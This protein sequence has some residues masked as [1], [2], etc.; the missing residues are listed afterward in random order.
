MADPPPHLYRREALAAGR[1]EATVRRIFEVQRAV[2]AHGAQPVYTLAHLAQLTGVSWRYLRD[3]VARR[4][5]PYL[6]ISRP[7]RDGT[8]RPIASPEPV[9]MDVQRWL[10][11][12]V[13]CACDVDPAAY[14]YR[15]GRSIVDC[16]R[17]H[18]GARWLVKLDLHDFFGT[19]GERRVFRVF[20]ALG[21]PSLLS[22]EMTRL[23]TRVVIGGQ[24]RR[25]FY[26]Y[27]H[28]APYSV[29]IEGALPQ[30][31]PTSGALANAAMHSAD[32][33]LAELASSE[34]LVY[35]RYSDDI[36]LSAGTD[37]TR[38]RG[39]HVVNRAAAILGGAGFVLHRAKSRVVP[40][41]A[42]HVVL[43]LIVGEDEVRL[44]PEYKRRL[45]LH[46]RG[47][48]R[49][50]LAEHARSRHFDSI[51]SMINHVDG[52]IAFAASV[53]PV[54]AR[55]L[56][57]AWDDALRAGGYPMEPRR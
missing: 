10:L 28:K 39:A 38:R 32:A 5:D 8:T 53:D 27:S 6:D 43:G 33:A 26:R 34:G 22:L 55:R 44:L 14:A 56:H 13:V 36:T 4:R 12:N 50:G 17:M 18:V 21:Y 57:D 52:G 47:V 1:D 15:R 40:P 35:T 2:A 42:R 51:L 20:E 19:V 45:E 29:Q 31:A 24:R 11:R 25:L 49:F 7:K 3:V 37:F 9:L 16:A 48:A 54:F 23:C 41:G 30:G 46:V